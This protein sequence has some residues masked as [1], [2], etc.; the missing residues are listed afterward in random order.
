MAADL[1]RGLRILLVEFGHARCGVPFKAQR[2]Q[3]AH[4]VLLRDRR[5]LVPVA[6]LVGLGREH[7]EE[8]VEARVEEGGGVG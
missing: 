3:R 8:L 7:L 2:A 6:G 4:Q 5:L 1:E